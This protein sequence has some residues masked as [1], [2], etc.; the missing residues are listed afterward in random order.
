[1]ELSTKT[2]PLSMAARRLAYNNTTKARLQKR[3]PREVMTSR[4]Y[5][6]TS[7]TSQ[8]Q[9][10]RPSKKDVVFTQRKLAKKGREGLDTLDSA[11]KSVTTPEGIAA[12]GPE[13][14]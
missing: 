9:G 14:H 2:T 11:P 4:T 1:M 7:R 6:R 13:I 8:H 12:A 3:C 5:L 10:H